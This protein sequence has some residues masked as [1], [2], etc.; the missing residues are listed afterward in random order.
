MLAG[1]EQASYEMRRVDKWR[2]GRANQSGGSEE[3]VGRVKNEAVAGG[4]GRWSSEAWGNGGGSRIDSHTTG[5]VFPAGE[6]HV[7]TKTPCIQVACL[8]LLG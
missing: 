5:Y 1:G 6:L 2:V 4:G 3:A 7:T 8:S